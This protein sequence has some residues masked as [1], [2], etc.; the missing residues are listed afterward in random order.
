MSYHSDVIIAVLIISLFALWYIWK[1]RQDYYMEMDP[2]VVR[3]KTKLLPTFP[4]LALVKMIKS[5]ASYTID[6]RKIYLCTEYNG[7]LYDDN[8]LTYVILHELA[9]VL[10]PEIGHGAEFMK[11]FSRLLTVAK[12]NGLWDENKPRIE[13]YCKA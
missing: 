1:N 4:Q 9:H 5:D 6:K 10:T 3:L 12:T 13:N 7:T 8:M 11:T 2:V